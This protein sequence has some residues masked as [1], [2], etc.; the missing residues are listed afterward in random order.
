ML[1]TCDFASH[2]RRRHSCPA[3]QTSSVFV[4]QLPTCLESLSVGRT[5]FNRIFESGRDFLGYDIGGLPPGPSIYTNRGPGVMVS[6]EP[7]K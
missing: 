3:V 6:D 2:L 1:T 5:V 4:S 7:H